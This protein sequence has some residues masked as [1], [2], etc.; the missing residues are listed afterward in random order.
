MQYLSRGGTMPPAQ[1]FAGE[2]DLGYFAFDPSH[3]EYDR[4][5]LH[6][7]SLFGAENV[8]VVTQEALQSDMD[9][10]AQTIARFSGNTRFDGLTDAARQVQSASYPEY[11]V[12]FLRR[13]NHVQRSTLNPAPVAV[14]GETPFGLYRGVGY[15]AR[16]NPMARRLKTRKPVSDFVSKTFSGYYTASNARL[17]DLVGETVD[18]TD[19]D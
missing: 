5:L 10:V 4:L 13:V 2:T 11:A 1:F 14:F 17:R 16:R 19:Y 3:F 18:L 8:L 12:P 9:G 6:Y 15:L 7:Q